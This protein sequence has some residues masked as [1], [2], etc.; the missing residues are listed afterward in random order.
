MLCL[1][2]L[3]LVPNSNNLQTLG[4]IFRGGV[5]K[6]VK[7]QTRNK[8][9]K[10]SD[11]EPFVHSWHI[12]GWEN[13]TRLNLT[14]ALNLETVAT[15]A[16]KCTS[17]CCRGRKRLDKKQ[18]LRRC[19]WHMTVITDLMSRTLRAVVEKTTSLSPFTTFPLSNPCYYFVVIM[20]SSCGFIFRWKYN[21]II[22]KNIYSV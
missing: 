10:K 5:E 7:K 1:Y 15:A 2:S 8:K 20:S 3:H 19:S 12:P 6:W 13:G 16:D 22:M 17:L 21:I 9:Q 11:S 18:P 4:G 14:I